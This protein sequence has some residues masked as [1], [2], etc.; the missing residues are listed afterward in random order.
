MRTIT[1]WKISSESL[2]QFDDNSIGGMVVCDSAD[3]AKTMF[4]IFINK[5]NPAQ[6]T[7]EDIFP[8]SMIREAAPEYGTY[9]D[10]QAKKAD[11]PL[12]LHD[13]G[14]KDERKEEVEKFKAGE[15]DLLFL[16]TICC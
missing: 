10:R 5:Y 6:K 2:T 12:I 15:I 3:Q 4:N 8:Y 9:T 16:S 7:I 11:R 13:I 14:L 1:L